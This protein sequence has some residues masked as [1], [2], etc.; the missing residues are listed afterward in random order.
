MRA[1]V[2]EQVR[3]LGTAL[4]LVRRF[5]LREW[6]HIQSIRALP[7]LGEKW[8]RSRYV[9]LDEEALRKTRRSDTVFIFGSGYSLNDLSAEEWAHIAAHDTIGFNYSSRQRW[10]RTDYH[11]VGE[12]FTADDA[13]R[14]RWWPGIE[15]YGRLIAGNPMYE[16]TI[17]GLQAGWFAYQSNRLAASGC[18]RK[19]TRIFRYKRIARGLFRPPT[20][21]IADGLVHGAGSLSDVVN[22]AYA[23][24]WRQIVIAGVDLYDSRYFWLGYDETRPDMMLNRGTG[25]SEQHPT[26]DTLIPYLKGWRELM[27]RDGVA[28][29]VYN[30]RSL[31]ARVLPVYSAE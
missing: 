7:W 12:I 20:R 14:S 13:R 4:A 10:V 11:I 21:A 23:M 16:H 15:E 26:A 29:T 5:D 22:F 31:L 30:P 28:L 17:V 8:S 6:L 9:V 1:H 2:L 3:R 25:H 24:G 27:E 19:G 18:L